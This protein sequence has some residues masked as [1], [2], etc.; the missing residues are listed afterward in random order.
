MLLQH[1]GTTYVT[2]MKHKFIPNI[3]HNQM[4]YRTENKR[5]VRYSLHTNLL[6]LFRKI[7]NVHLP[8][9]QHY[10]IYPASKAQSF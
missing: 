8:N 5:N 7:R 1:N 9:T 6:M 4:N 2:T 3:T 10:Y